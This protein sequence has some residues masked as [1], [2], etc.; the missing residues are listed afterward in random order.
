[1]EVLLLNSTFG[2]VSGERC[3]T[4]VFFPYVPFNLWLGILISMVLLVN[5]VPELKYWLM[6][7]CLAEEEDY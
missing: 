3:I 4:L 2:F 6:Q 7:F 5:A 1:M